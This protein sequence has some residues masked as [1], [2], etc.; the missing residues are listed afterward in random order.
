MT[1]LYNASAMTVLYNDNAMTVLC[2]NTM[3]VLC[4]N[5]VT[6]L[7]NTKTHRCARIF[8]YGGSKDTSVEKAAV[9]RLSQLSHFT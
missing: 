2:N 8:K 4:N 9:G 5:T 3:T 1:V 7:C 6:V